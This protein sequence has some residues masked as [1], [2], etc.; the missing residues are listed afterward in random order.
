MA[1]SVTGVLWQ[2]L[3]RPAE[4]VALPRQRGQ[5][6]PQASFWHRY[7]KL[8]ESGWCLPATGVFVYPVTQAGRDVTP[9]FRRIL[10]NCGVFLKAGS[11]GG[12]QGTHC[13]PTF[14]GRF[15]RAERRGARRTRVA[16]FSDPCGVFSAEETDNECAES[17]GIALVS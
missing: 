11:S 6:A 16:A 14:P 3:C 8:V 12:K 5:C 4:V 15:Q 7:A 9:D 1:V 10:T 13:L 17:N 2:S